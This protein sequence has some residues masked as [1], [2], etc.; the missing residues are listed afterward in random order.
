ML[1]SQALQTASVSNGSQVQLLVGQLACKS[2]IVPLVK[3]K[4][5]MLAVIEM[6]GLVNKSVPFRYSPFG[7]A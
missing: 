6:S 4:G 1:L 2:G 5:W 3:K 7:A